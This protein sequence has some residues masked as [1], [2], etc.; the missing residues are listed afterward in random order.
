MAVQNLA[1]VCGVSKM[2]NLMALAIYCT[3]SC[4]LKGITNPAC[5]PWHCTVW[6][7]NKTQP[8]KRALAGSTKSWGQ[9]YFSF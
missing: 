6:Q 4:K 5:S 1:V 9:S 7:Q 2:L 3:D 8:V